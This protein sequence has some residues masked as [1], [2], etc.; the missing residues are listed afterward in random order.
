PRLPALLPP[1]GAR[2]R[3]PRP[4]LGGSLRGR[5]RAA[6]GRPARA[7]LARPRDVLRLRLGG[8][9][10]LPPHRIPQLAEDPRPARW[11]ARAGRAAV[12]PRARRGLPA[13]IAAAPGPAE[14]LRRLGHRLPR[15]DPRA[16]FPER[17]A[18]ERLV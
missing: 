18:A 11:S 7:R 2:R 16:A 6:R 3:D 13:A 9:R 1:R 17:I 5:R 8:P 12:D 4:D 15:G 10:G 14:R